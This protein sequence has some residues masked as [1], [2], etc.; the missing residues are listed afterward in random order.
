MTPIGHFAIAFAAKPST[1]KTHLWIL[2]AASWLLDMLYFVF[3]FAGIE[4]AENLAHPGILPSPWSH[5]LFMALVWSGLAALISWKIFHSQRIGTI[6]GLVAF[7]HWVLDLIAWNNIELYPGS[8]TQIGLGMIN[9]LGGS[10]VFVEL[11]LLLFGLI[12]YLAPYMRN[13]R[14]RPALNSSLN[15]RMVIKDVSPKG[16]NQ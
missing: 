1:S 11:G 13:A 3:A 8:S 14:M 15:S 12:V 16:R 6:V 2:L 10:S 7:S 5:S 9:H 4:S